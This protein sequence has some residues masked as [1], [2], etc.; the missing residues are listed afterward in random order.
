MIDIFKM[1][2][3]G[4]LCAGVAQSIEVDTLSSFLRAAILLTLGAGWTIA[5]ALHFW[6][7]LYD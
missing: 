1:L 3:V 2:T 6:R 7:Y 5:A 4:A